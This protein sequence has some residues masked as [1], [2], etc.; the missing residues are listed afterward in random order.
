MS[1]QAPYVAI[2]LLGAVRRLGLFLVACALLLGSSG[3]A[4]AMLCELESESAELMSTA[5]LPS[6][7]PPEAFFGRATFG[8]ASGAQECDARFASDCD[9]KTPSGEPQAPSPQTQLRP[10]AALGN[11]QHG[12]IPPAQARSIYADLRGSCLAGH[13]AQLYRPP[14]S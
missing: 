9:I 11:S 12:L 1:A 10:S 13:Y 5:A 3:S 14:R 7:Q 6:N 2:P 4:Q 8:E